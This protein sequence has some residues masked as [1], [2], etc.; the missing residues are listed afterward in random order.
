MADLDGTDD[1]FDSRDVIE[2]IE[3]LK[4]EW[5]EATEHDP[6]EFVMFEDDWAVGLGEEGA[7]EL[8]ALEDLRSE[9]SSSEFDFGITFIREDYFPE[10]VQEL[11]SDVGDM[12]REIPGYIVIDWD[13]TADNLRIDY[14]TVE[15]R[16]ETYLYR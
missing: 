4:D 8:M 1:I 12:P 14:S 13:A 5:R 11:V 3:A 10:Y 7:A 6:D 2:R 16:G 15:F 9:I